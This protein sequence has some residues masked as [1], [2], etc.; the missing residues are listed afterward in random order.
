MTET[1]P[2]S[3]AQQFQAIAYLRWRLFINSFR[4]KGGTGELIAR[5]LVFPF[6]FIILAGI[7]TGSGGAAYAAASHGHLELLAAVF[8][9]IFALQIVVSINIAAPGLS[10][11]PASLIRFPLNFRRYLLVRLFLGLLSASTVAGTCA[12]LAA[13]TGIAVAVPSLAL[14]AFVVVLALALTNMLFTRM[15]FAWVDRWLSTRRAREFFTAFIILFSIGIQYANVTFNGLGKHVDPTERQAKIDTAIRVYRW[16]SPALHAFPPGLAGRALQHAAT[17]KTSVALLFIA[18]I[19]VFAAAFLA[20]FAWRMQREY[21]GENLS[22]TS[23]QSTRAP[24]LQA[25]DP[26]TGPRVPH[27]STP[28]SSMSGITKPRSSILTTE[29][30]PVLTALLTKEWTYMRRNPAQYYGLLAPLAMVFLFA[31]RMGRFGAT[32]MIFPA[33]AAYSMLGVSALAYNIL[34]M[35]ATGIQFYYLSPV[36]FHT[37]FLA[38]NLFSFAIPAIQIILIYAL[39]AFTVGAPGLIITLSVLAWII[40]A[41]IVNVTLGNLRSISA[42]KKI[43]PAKVSRRQASQLSAFIALVLMLVV[44][45]LGFAVLFLSRTIRLDW[46]PIPVFLVLAAGA[47]ALYWTQLGRVDS[48]AA[49]HRETLLAELTKVE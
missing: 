15:V 46:L 7:I 40:F 26:T 43:D 30:N 49:N 12:L 37:I 16:F 41:T 38:K 34:G 28:L 8:W 39:M 42:P 1:T 22:E 21:R 19:L 45:G 13:A 11:D 20:V 47:F 24:S 4:R 23:P 17:G 36:A 27:S 33:A 25:A 2:I 35:D 6:A 18:A 14:P 32:G 10:F 29:R 31:A 5:I 48:M 3:A 44:I 9:G